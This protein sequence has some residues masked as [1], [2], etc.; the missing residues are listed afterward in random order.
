ME[1]DDAAYYWLEVGLADDVPSHDGNLGEA[2]QGCSTVR[3][4]SD[5]EVCRPSPSVPKSIFS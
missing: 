3:D 5:R 2:I 4:A 1:L